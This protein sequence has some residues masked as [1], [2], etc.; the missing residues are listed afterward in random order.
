MCPPRTVHSVRIVMAQDAQTQKYPS[1]RIAQVTIWD[2]LKMILTEG[3]P[4]GHI[5]VG[6]RF[7]VSASHLI[8]RLS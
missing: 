4:P 1:N 2:N 3:K 7:L 5:E 8:L 6:Q